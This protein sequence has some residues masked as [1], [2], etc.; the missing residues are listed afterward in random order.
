MQSSVR[1]LNEVRTRKLVET[2][3]DDLHSALRNLRRHPTFSLTIAATLSI[4]IGA[5]VGVFGVIDR[6]MIR[7]LPFAHQEQLFFVE[8]SWP[9]F[10]DG[11][12]TG[13]AHAS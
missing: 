4:A 7:P 1:P 6:L 2:L 9:L 8:N 10:V 5:T 11:A 13:G 3:R 12:N